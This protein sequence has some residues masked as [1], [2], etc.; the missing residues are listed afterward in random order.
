MGSSATERLLS[1]RP[2][3][4]VVLT[5]GTRPGQLERAVASVLADGSGTD[6]VGAGAGRVGVVVVS[7]GAGPLA[8]DDPRVSVLEL[9]ENVGAPGG[10]DAAVRALGDDVEVVGF[11]DDD[12]ELAP[13]SSRRILERFASEPDLGVTTFRLVD[14]RGDTQRRH[15]PR[16]GAEGAER[17]GEVTLFLEGA[18][19][20][21]RAAYLDAGGYFT[22]LVYA[23][24]AL[25]FSWRLVERGWTIRYVTDV[26]VFHPR[27]TIGRHPDGWRR[28]GRNRVWIARRTLPWPVAVVHVGLWLVEGTRR[29]PDGASRRAYLSGWRSG[30]RQPVDRDPISW[31]TV[32]RLTRLGRPPVV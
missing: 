4:W 11:L 26:S 29:A 9:E 28:T 15:L 13:D 31:R 8:F 27:T 21:R 16:I 14:E 32:L 6:D 25:E 1:G 24:E 30:W 2:L 19:A 20:I 10:R 23:H 22:E 5:T 12:A 18:C 7:N 3:V 17:A